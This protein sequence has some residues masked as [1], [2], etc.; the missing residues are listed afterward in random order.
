MNS[1]ET[2]YIAKNLSDRIALGLTIIAIG[3]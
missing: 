2:H 3:K 1:Q